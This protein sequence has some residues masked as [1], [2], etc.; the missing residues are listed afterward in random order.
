MAIKKYLWFF[1]AAIFF[2]SCDTFQHIAKTDVRYAVVTAE[3]APAENAEIKATI[4]PYKS[5]LDAVMNEVIAVLPVELSKQKPES[6]LGNWVA[7]VILE[8]LNAEGYNVDF[9][10]V[11]YGGLRVPYLAAGEITRGEVF[12]LSP[13]DNTLM[14]LEVP[15]IVLDSA[16]LLIAQAD[17]WPVSKGINMVIQQKKVVSARIHNQPVDP[18]KIYRVATLDYVAN[19]GDNMSMFIPIKRTQTGLLLRDILIGHL[20]KSTREGIPVSA[21]I[22]GRIVQQ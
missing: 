13:F 18:E 16:L 9:A 3:T 10:I 15:G 22:E 2:S 19:G 1:T 17:G 8:K 21:K 12:E 11:N 6:T 7:D 4:A 5:Q 14:V 20:Q